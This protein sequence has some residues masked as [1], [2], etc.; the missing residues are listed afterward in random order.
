[1]SSSLQTVRTFII[2]T[3]I[4]IVAMIPGLSGAVLAVCL[5]V[6]ERLIAD[7]ADLRH[8]LKE[9]FHFILLIVVGILVGTFIVSFGLDYVLEN[10]EAI[11]YLFFTGLII[12]QLPSLLKQTDRTKP[13]T[14][15]NILALAIGLGV[16]VVM[17]ILIVLEDPQQAVFD[18]NF[19]AYICMIGIGFVFAISHLI[20]G[21]SG[22]TIMAVLG[23]L[24]VLTSAIKD[25]DFAFL[26]PLCFGLLL[27]VLVFAKIVHRAITNHRN[28]TYSVVI[29]LTIGSIGVMLLYV[30]PEIGGWEDIA[31]GILFF[32]V[33]ILVSVALSKLGKEPFPETSA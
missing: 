1:M 31:L 23:V 24:T 6:Y 11:A 9:D 30:Y 32:F 2:G 12:G 15:A 5:G 7:L 26:I 20:P 8:K 17:G 33:G 16:M 10:Y 21:I 27:G 22:T 29:G 18:H 25:L 14:K 4:G 19:A 28:T 3:I 13:V